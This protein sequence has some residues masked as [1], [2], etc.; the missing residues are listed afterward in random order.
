MVRASDVWLRVPVCWPRSALALVA[1][2]GFVPRLALLACWALYLSFTSVGWPFLNFQWDA[3]LLEAG[4]LAVVWAP[5]GLRPS[6]RGERAP[7]R[8]TRWLVLWLLFRLMMLSGLVKLASG[9]ES[10]RDGSALDFHYWSQPL[11]H[12]LVVRT[13]DARG[14]LSMVSCSR[15]SSER[16]PAARSLGRRRLRQIAAVAVVFLMATIAATG[17]YGFF[18]F[19]TCVLCLRCSTTAPGGSLAQAAPVAAITTAPAALWR[20]VVLGARRARGVA[21]SARALGEP[22]P[23]GRAENGRIAAEEPEPPGGALRVLEGLCAPVPSLAAPLE[24][25]TLRPLPR[26]DEGA[27]EILVRAALTASRGSHTSSATSR[28][29]S[30]A[31][32]SSRALYMPRLDWQLWLLFVGLEYDRRWRSDW[33]RAFLRR[34]PEGS[35]S[36][37]GLLRENPFPDSPP[38]ARFSARRSPSTASARPRSARRPATGG[39]AA[40]SALPAGGGAVRTPATRSRRP[41]PR[42]ELGQD[43]PS[44]VVEKLKRSCT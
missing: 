8:V 16:L 17:N 18:N 36:V 21:T 43:A 25:S 40:G 33:T 11:P 32:P 14:S 12:Q 22:E 20:S 6:G 24:A 13:R 10:W 29:S 34:L 5:G 9:D 7:A 44:D 26:D 30:R 4:L 42:R 35:L 37:L 2:A 15:S 41:R 31:R 38:R 23:F 1:L 28:S 19:L 3:L 27:P 39:S